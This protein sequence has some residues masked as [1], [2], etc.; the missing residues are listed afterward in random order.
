MPPSR[1]LFPALFLV[2]LPSC[3]GGGSDR[4]TYAT[5][6]AAP[7]GLAAGTVLTFVSGEN[8]SPVA[9]ATV[10]VG[11]QGQTTDTAGQVRLATLVPFGTS[12]DIVHPAY[13]DRLTT[14]RSGTGPVFNL[15]PRTNREGL[16]EHY[17][18]S[19]LYTSTADGSP[20]GGAGLIRL[21]RGTTQVVV[22]PSPQLLE[23]GPAME[24]HYAAVATLN[25]AVGGTVTY[26][27][28]PT[29]PSGGVVFTTRVDPNDQRCV[30]L[31]IRGYMRGVYRGLELTGGEVVLCEPTVARS[32]TVAHELGHSF[33]LLHGPE[34]LDLMFNGFSRNRAATFGP[35]ESILMRL[36]LD[37]PAGNRFPDNDRS[38]QAV[39]GVEERV[40]VCH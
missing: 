20:V 15:W 29:R 36:M 35:R 24:A 5:V 34:P 23:D 37:R 18:A 25:E 7:T 10:T 30:D 14:L 1:R 19:L 11:G 22:V 13:L 8:G 32:P 3:G 26:V 28:A 27:L 21:A 40:I 17:T 2:L 33:G 9:G 31:R 39:A 12:L 6:P 38:A 16:S 4:V